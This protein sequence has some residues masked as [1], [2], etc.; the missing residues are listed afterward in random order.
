[1][2]FVSRI[3]NVSQSLKRAQ[4]DSHQQKPAWFLAQLKPNSVQIAKRNL[5]RQ[6]FKTFLPME[7]QTLE[8]RGKFVTTTQPFFPGYIFVSF[9]AGKGHWGAV[10]STN[11][12]TKLVS[13]GNTPA[14]VP[15]GMIS[16]LMQR[17][18]ISGKLLPPVVLLPGDQVLLTSGPFANFVAEVE[19]TA[20]ER[21]VWVLMDV[22]GKKTRVTVNSDQI[23]SL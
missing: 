7:E 1:M 5:E 12:I 13:F 20:P 6:G 23:R 2:I 21:R 10:N 15:A 17:C 18:D 9:E 3:V 22:L 8:R 4:M 11:G 14:I 19:K 16:E